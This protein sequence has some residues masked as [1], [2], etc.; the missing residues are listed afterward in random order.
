MASKPKSAST[1]ASATTTRAP[2]T[3]KA[4]TPVAQELL[5]TAT[6]AAKE[7]KDKIKEA[8]ALGKLIEC[9]NGLSKWGIHQLMLQIE[10]R[11]AQLDKP[12]QNSIG[13]NADTGATE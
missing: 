10:L 2:R 5:N 13:Q 12:E 7:A 6:L 1:G 11:R 8:K 3:P 4:L 9:V